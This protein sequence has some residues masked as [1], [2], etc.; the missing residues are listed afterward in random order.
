MK[1]FPTIA[2]RP[3]PGPVIV[4]H[5]RLRRYLLSLASAAEEC[6]NRPELLPVF[7]G[8]LA[9]VPRTVEEL[10]RRLAA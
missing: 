5:V 4:Q 8:V 3:V 1:N 10:E 7:L 6:A 2:G 9:M